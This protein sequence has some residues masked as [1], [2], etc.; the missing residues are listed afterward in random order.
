M[1]G[2]ERVRK[3]H[4]SKRKQHVQG[5]CGEKSQSWNRSRLEGRAKARHLLDLL[6]VTILHGGCFG[7][8]FIC[9]KTK[10][11]SLHNIIQGHITSKR[12]SGNQAYLRPWIIPF[13]AL[14]LLINAPSRQRIL[15]GFLL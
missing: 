4:P 11:Q 7:L 12:L 1:V 2:D 15:K 13:Y 8:H 6:F 9:E 5:S 14:L 3:E 10:A